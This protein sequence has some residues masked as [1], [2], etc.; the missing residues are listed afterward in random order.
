[1]IRFRKA[2][3]IASNVSLIAGAAIGIYAGIQT[4]L[5]Y[6]SLPDG[7]CPIDP[8][9]PWLYAAAALCV[10]SLFLSFFETKKSS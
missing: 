5:L 6:L 10:L 9:R 2:L 8:N 1:M 3:A 7:M 4:Y